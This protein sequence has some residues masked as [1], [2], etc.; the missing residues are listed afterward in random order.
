[1]TGALIVAAMG[2]IPNKGRVALTMLV[3]LG[4]VMAAFAMSQILILSFVMLFLAGDTVAS[5]SIQWGNYLLPML[6]IWALGLFIV[7]RLKRLH[8]SLTYILSFLAL[9]VAMNVRMRRFVN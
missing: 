5:L 6:V 2:N 4:L 3:V 1:V 9:G 8:I 7:G